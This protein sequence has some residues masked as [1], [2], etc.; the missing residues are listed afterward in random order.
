[1]KTFSCIVPAYNEQEMLPLT[2]PTILDSIKSIKNMQGKLIVVDNNSSDKTAEIARSLGAE[3]VFEPVNQI[4]KA[5]NR[6]GN[7]CVDDDYLLF[8]DA[9]TYMTPELL[10]ASLEALESGKI[11][12]GGC[13]VKMDSD[14]GKVVTFVWTMI[15][16]ITNLAA[17]AFIFCLNR[18]F[19]E[20]GGFNEK[21]YAAEDVYFSAQLKRWGRKNGRLKFRIMTNHKIITSDRKMRWYSPLQI[22]KMLLI[23]TL[24]PWRLKNRDKLEFWYKRPASV[25]DVNDSKEVNKNNSQ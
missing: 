20:T 16:S 5:R 8:I 25:D 1:M 6:G 22:I 9:D 2:L 18:A 13:L 15:T 11:C 12:G 4:S 14:K 10:K 17:G 21:I 3:V 23:L 24:M 7:H 19:Q